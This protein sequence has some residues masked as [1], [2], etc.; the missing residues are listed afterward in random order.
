MKGFTA[1]ISASLGLKQNISTS[2]LTRFMNVDMVRHS[3]RINDLP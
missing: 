3:H 1:K 2:I